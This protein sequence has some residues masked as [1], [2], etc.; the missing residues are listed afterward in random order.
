ME[1]RHIEHKKIKSNKNIEIENTAV[2]QIN[3]Y[4]RIIFENAK[5]N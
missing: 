1:L 4:R 5:I 3:I 2:V